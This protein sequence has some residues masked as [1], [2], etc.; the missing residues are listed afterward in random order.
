MSRAFHHLKYLGFF[1]RRVGSA[2]RQFRRLQDLR[3]GGKAN[4]ATIRRH[5]YPANTTWE[6]VSV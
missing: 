3:Q 5:F 1:F 6:G 4:P 2:A